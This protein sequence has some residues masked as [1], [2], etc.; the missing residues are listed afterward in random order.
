MLCQ[1]AVECLIDACL[2]LDFALKL[3]DKHRTTIGLHLLL[4]F[5]VQL[6]Q[7]IVSQE[8]K[9]LVIVLHE[10]KLLLISSHLSKVL[11][12]SKKAQTEVSWE[13]FLLK[14]EPELFKLVNNSRDERGKLLL[15]RVFALL[16]LLLISGLRKHV[17]ERVLIL[18]MSDE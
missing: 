15:L 12:L 13:D 11:S 5:L 2:N 8:Q 7:H 17:H 1:K 18:V 3:S 10:V 14:N 9:V 16:D 6:A 4:H